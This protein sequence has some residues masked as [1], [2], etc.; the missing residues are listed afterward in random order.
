MQHDFYTYAIEMK[1][2][3][4]KQ[5]QR[6]LTLESEISSLRAKIQQITNQRSV[7]IEKIEYKFDQLKIEKLDGTLNIGVN[8]GEVE[9][10]VD[11][12]VN[13]MS[14]S[15]SAAFTTE[16]REMVSSQITAEVTAFIDREL[17]ELIAQ[18]ETQ[19]G[20]RFDGQYDNF[21]RED[22]FKQLPERIEFYLNHHPYNKNIE[23]ANEYTEKIIEQIKT[24]ISQAIYHFL[25]NVQQGMNTVI[26][27]DV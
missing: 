2:Y 21:I 9:E 12:T 4:E 16:Q 10:F 27:E 20:A 15:T 17:S 26:K 3:L 13:N 11:S 7:T 19:T 14:S 25:Q 1:K 22:L 18:H 5:E 6:I 8:P 24:D 23:Q